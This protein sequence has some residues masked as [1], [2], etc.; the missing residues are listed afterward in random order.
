M[1]IG[2]RVLRALE[3]MNSARGRRIVGT[4]YDNAQSARPAPEVRRTAPAGIKRPAEMVR[5][6]SL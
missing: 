2:E 4:A 3:R 5:P 6:R 1:A